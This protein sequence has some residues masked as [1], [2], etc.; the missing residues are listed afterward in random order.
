M[1]RELKPRVPDAAKR[2]E[3][4]MVKRSILLC[5]LLAITA[6]AFAAEVKSAPASGT[7][8]ADSSAK[9]PAAQAASTDSALKQAAATSTDSALQAG[10]GSTDSALKPGGVGSTDS[11]LV[12]S[13]D[14]ALAAPKTSEE[15]LKRWAGAY[16]GAKTFYE[17]ARF[18]AR[19]EGPRQGDE[20]TLRVT[21]A[22]RRSDALRVDVAGQQNVTFYFDGGKTTIYN[23][24]LN[25][26]VQPQRTLADLAAT[27]Q[28]FTTLAAALSEDPYAFMMTDVTKI[29]DLKS[30]QFEGKEVY[31]VGL[32]QQGS[33]VVKGY[34]D[35]Q[36]M[37]L[38]GVKVELPLSDGFGTAQVTEIVD[39]VLI[40]ELPKDSSGKE[41]E[42]FSFSLPEG[43]KQVNSD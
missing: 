34:F 14:S 30:S 11:A 2:K 17:E 12:G 41:I 4:S 18:S 25:E 7:A 29:E 6:L 13:T 27:L 28:H 32:Q 38:V 8:S 20:R 43:A 9:A 39:K 5:T 35:K 33:V 37:Y 10:V 16:R 19:V 23:K 1:A 42:V 40:D 26:Y 36:K 22:F 15:L 31:E 21:T 24:D 3:I